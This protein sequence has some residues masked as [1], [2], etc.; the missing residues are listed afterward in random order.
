[1]LATD[2]MCTGTRFILSI[3]DFFE[4]LDDNE[5]AVVDVRNYDE[6]PVIDGFADRR[7]P[8]DVL[9]NHLDELD[10]DAIVFVSQTGVRSQAAAELAAAYG[11]SMRLY[12]LQGGFEE[13]VRR[14][15]SA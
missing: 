14:K 3:D 15:T 4:L 5:V 11:L 9:E 8:M 12:S 7:L 6:L 13:W 1:M 2:I 10:A